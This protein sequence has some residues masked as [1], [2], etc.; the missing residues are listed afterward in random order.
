MMDRPFTRNELINVLRGWHKFLT[1][2]G[3]SHE[4]NVQA[5]SHAADL[6]EKLTKDDGGK[7]DETE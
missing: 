4:R 3:R 2:T 6:L 1:R 7:D 5:L